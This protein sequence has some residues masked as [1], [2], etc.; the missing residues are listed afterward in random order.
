MRG[1]QLLIGVHQIRIGN[2]DICGDAFAALQANPKS[3]T[4]RV[5]NMLRQIRTTT[6][7]DRQPALRTIVER[8]DSVRT[9]FEDRQLSTDDAL[10][11]IQSLL[12]E[13]NVAEQERK[14]LGLDDR[15][16]GVYWVLRT[17]ALEHNRKLADE[18]GVLVAA[19]SA[20]IEADTR[21]LATEIV[22]VF[23]RFP[24]FRQSADEL[25]QLKAELYKALLRVV[26]GRRMV[27]LGD[28]ILGLRF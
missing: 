28:R 20:T 5:M 18:K 26:S 24:N 27:D 21:D 3:D 1:H 15:T 6:D 16:F 8:V 4:G 14:R 12:D 9:A 17:E 2:N 22:E 25:R 19:D 13:R 10:R 7:V 11:Q 23:K